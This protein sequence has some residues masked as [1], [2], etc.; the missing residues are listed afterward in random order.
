MDIIMQTSQKWEDNLLAWANEHQID[1]LIGKSKEELLSLETLKISFE[2][3]KKLDGFV[4]PEIEYLQN[5][6]DLTLEYLYMLEVFPLEITRLKNL[7][8]LKLISLRFTMIPDEIGQL[9]NLEE[10]VIAECSYVESLPLSLIEIPSLKIL[11]IEECSDL[12]V[13]PISHKPLHN[14]KK[15][16]IQ[17]F[18]R[19]CIL[20]FLK[21]F[22]ELE[23]LGLCRIPF[24]DFPLQLCSLTNLKDLTMRDTKI[25]K[26]PAEIANLKQL[27]ILICDALTEIPEE[28]CHLPKLKE[29]DYGARALK[30]LPP[31][32]DKLI[33]HGYIKIKDCEFI[34]TVD[35]LRNIEL[36]KRGFE[37]VE[38]YDE[39]IQEYQK[40][41]RYIKQVVKKFLHSKE[42]KE[43]LDDVE[44]AYEEYLKEKRN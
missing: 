9:T 24:V 5:L 18:R 11:V 6:K 4:P 3:S 23:E 25:E 31:S 36:L 19:L 38:S 39:Y 40:R 29:F 21:Q 32:I 42:T 8:S 20:D 26:L 1:D 34:E 44:E 22:P 33:A 35:T 10:F 15:L 28:V 12:E 14:L 7:Q 2:K 16:V 37:I 13:L 41:N 30:E 27:E 43:E 17:F